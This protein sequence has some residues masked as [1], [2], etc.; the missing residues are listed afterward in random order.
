MGTVNTS[1][2]LDNFVDTCKILKN[3]KQLG[4]QEYYLKIFSA[5]LKPSFEAI[6]KRVLLNFAILK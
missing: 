5:S 2:G 1:H 3:T 4:I 6:N